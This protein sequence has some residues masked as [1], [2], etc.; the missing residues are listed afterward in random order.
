MS[1]SGGGDRGWSLSPTSEM[2][3]TKALVSGSAYLGLSSVER[4]SSEAI[5]QLKEVIALYSL[6]ADKPQNLPIKAQMLKNRLDY[7]ERLKRI[8]EIA[9]TLERTLS[10]AI[11]LATSPTGLNLRPILPAGGMG[12]PEIRLELPL[13]AASSLESPGKDSAFKRVSRQVTPVDS[14][15]QPGP[16]IAKSVERP[17]LE[18][19]QT[20][21]TTPEGVGQLG[22]ERSKLWLESLF[23]DLKK[24]ETELDND[25]KKQVLAIF[26]NLA[27]QNPLFQERFAAL[28]LIDFLVEKILLG[29]WSAKLEMTVFWTLT[30][31]VS[32]QK[33]QDTV[34]RLIP[35]LVE[36]LVRGFESIRLFEKS[37]LKEFAVTLLAALIIQH[38]GNQACFFGLENSVFLVRRLIQSLPTE[39]QGTQ[40]SGLFFLANV[41]SSPQ[42][43]H[44]I[45]AFK[46]INGVGLLESYLGG[47]ALNDSRV[48]DQEII[49]KALINLLGI[50]ETRVKLKSLETNKINKKRRAV[51][52][53]SSVEKAVTEEYEGA[54][55]D[56][57]IE[58]MDEMLNDLGKPLETDRAFNKLDSGLKTSESLAEVLCI[59]DFPKKLLYLM[60]DANP[61]II[62][63]A[64]LVLIHLIRALDDR[65]IKAFRLEK[66]LLM[67][68]FFC[69]QQ[70]CM[71][72]VKNE[73]PEIF[74]KLF[75]A[76]T[77]E[78]SSDSVI[79]SHP[80]VL[81]FLRS[82]VSAD[83]RFKTIQAKLSLL[84]QKIESNPSATS[85]TL[86]SL[87]AP[88]PVPATADVFKTEVVAKK[89]LRE[90]PA[91]STGTR[92]PE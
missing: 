64:A 89:R 51:G 24:T 8:E 11:P 44:Y 41:M 49:Q 33:N 62:K 55:C 27:R 65:H 34:G 81:G 78:D 15:V 31:M 47:V 63:N 80:E 29:G 46:E 22:E 42:Y 4:L 88:A 79:F 12:R 77:A 21:S 25:S 59:L 35:V 84:I 38:P 17:S 83:S 30:F 61:L 7:V 75:S 43:V 18:E 19:L 69:V 82:L 23:D 48:I 60:Q 58:E 73:L 86:G 67:P 76:S 40:D 45:E 28:G 10:P 2:A 54:Y 92:K 9:A 36:K 13:H 74:L 85:S 53:A 37:K 3:L 32:G 87:P 71:L 1:G 16:D 56:Y 50:R 66:T 68:L 39:A 14:N 91:S 90:D 57:S 26:A 20:L 72:K 52:V 6:L 70:P 5:K